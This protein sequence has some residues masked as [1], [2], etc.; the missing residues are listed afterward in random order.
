MSTINHDGVHQSWALDMA[1]DK[2]G[3]EPA[4]QS[5][6]LMLHNSSS[7]SLHNLMELCIEPALMDQKADVQSMNSARSSR[8]APSSV[9]S[10]LLESM[11]IDIYTEEMNQVLIVDESEWGYVVSSSLL[12]EVN[13]E[14]DRAT[15][16]VTT[17]TAVAKRLAILDSLENDMSKAGVI[18]MYRLIL[19]DGVLS[20]N[21]T[22]AGNL[23]SK[24]FNLIHNYVNHDSQNVL[25][26]DMPM[27]CLMVEQGVD[28]SGLKKK[29]HKLG[30]KHHIVKPMSR[31]DMIQCL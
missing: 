28:R 5:G 18:Q 7:R 22:D 26:V 11:D 16:T 29:L 3:E 9:G 15:N 25:Q 17:L 8:V 21:V 27:I 20:R 14:S 6:R 19:I 12:Q 4:E 30:I 1:D 24:L 13:I 23:V 10:E 2:D 31:R